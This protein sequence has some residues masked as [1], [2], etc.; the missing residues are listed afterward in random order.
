MTET[1]NNKIQN[2]PVKKSKFSLA[3]I[4]K[5][6]ALIIFISLTFGGGY[7]LGVNGYQARVDELT[8]VEITRDLP[9]ERQD[10][11]FSL[12]WRVWD[13]LDTKYYAPDQLDDTQMV[14]G[15][16]K[17]MVA[18]VE[19]P[20][21]VFLPPKKNKIVQED[22]QGNFSGVGIQI[23]IKGQQLVV[24]AP[25]P[26]SPAYNAG[27]EAGDSII[28]IRD[29]N[30]GINMSTVGITINEAVEA[31]RGEEGTKVTLVLQRED[32]EDTFE[33]EIERRS[34]AIPAVATEFVGEN[35]NIAHINIIKFSGEMYPDWNEAV[36]EV[37]TRPEVDKII[38]DVRNNPGGYMQGAVELASDFLEQGDVVVIEEERGKDPVEATVQRMARLGDRQVVVLI[39]KGSA[40]ASEIFAGALRDNEDI[41]LIGESTFGKGTIQEPQQ[42]E[43][44]VG[45]HITIAKWL[46]P[47]GYWVN[48]NGLEP[49][50]IV[51]DD[52]ET[53]E[54]E[55]LQRAIDFMET[56]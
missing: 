52:P 33:K 42:L 46:T 31:I 48:E 5:V 45:F 39:N 11:D 41:Q 6:L 3:T 14:Y 1:D 54:D 40:S 38:M 21:T 26:G 28:G 56:I 51:E 49:D 4:R 20:Y 13:T 53:T 2:K 32:V 35:E 18:A 8:K 43:N 27:V 16:I 24:V 44:G 10:L 29:L 25:L 7:L 34:I 36:E 9:P 47:S 50:I 30:K 55:Q 12:F 15:A 19:D 23:D 37:L 22:L 17:G